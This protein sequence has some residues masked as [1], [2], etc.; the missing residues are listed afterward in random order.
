MFVG[1]YGVSFAARR[2]H[3]QIPLWA[4][5]IAY[6][7]L[8]AAAWWLEDRHARRNDATTA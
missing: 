2:L 7:L 8:A 3:P 5:F 1:H 4:L 6:V